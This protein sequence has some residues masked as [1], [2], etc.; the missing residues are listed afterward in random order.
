ME[1]TLDAFQV[2]KAKALLIL[3]KLQSFLQQGQDAGVRIEENTRHKLDAALSS[4]SGEKLKI[5][6]VGG[7]SEGKTSI[8]AAWMEQLDKASMKISHRESSNEVVIYDVGAGFELIDTPGL[9]GFKEKFNADTHAIE[10]YKDITKKY[11]SEAH[12]LLYVMNPVNPIKESHQDDLMWL[13]RTLNLLPRTIFVLSRFDEVADVADKEEYQQ[14]MAIKRAS[15]IGRLG[16]LI[17]LSAAESSA[18]AIVGVAANP[19]DMGVHHWLDNLEQFKALSHIASLQSATS[20]KI[21]A[22]G[23][24]VAIADETRRSIIRD[25]L[26]RQLPIAVAIDEK[27]AVEVAKLESMSFSLS[28]QLT[29]T[30]GKISDAR[31]RLRSS[32]VEYFSDL[33]LQAQ[34]V[35]MDTAGE[36]FEREVGDEGIIVSNR[37]KNIFDRT[38]QSATLEVSKIQVSFEFEVNHFNG[39]VKQYG[40]QGLEYLRGNNLINN[41]SVL[42]ARDGLVSVGNLVGLDLG[43]YLKFK[44]WGASNLAKNINGAFAIAGLVLEAWDSLE[45]ARRQDAF[46]KLR[47]TMVDNFKKQRAELLELIDARTFN[48]TFFSDYVTLTGNVEEVRKDVARRQRQREK[49]HAWR[50]AGEVIDVEFAAI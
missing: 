7:F 18:L 10:K 44:P 38:L 28:K 25:V 37:L 29:V 33:I 1:H 36:F 27:E 22:N 6:L 2:K 5:A 43:K 42:G 8:A 30:D 50:E 39:M 9:F 45:Q 11:V 19:F 21:K 4:V 15:V 3:Q 13:F 48:E 20:E 24:A 16:D 49:F 23:G 35:T 32:I 26:T 46:G 34:G 47:E 31:V 40:K 41:K 14:S 12:L 17:G